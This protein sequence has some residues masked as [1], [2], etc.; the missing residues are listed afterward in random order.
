MA[1]SFGST[2]FADDDLADWMRE[3]AEKKTAFYGTR[4]SDRENG[5]NSDSQFYQ[6][7]LPRENNI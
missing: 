1:G 3:Y 4:K 5:V 7:I 2:E 6:N